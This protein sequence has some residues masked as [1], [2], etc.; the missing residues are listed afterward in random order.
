MSAEQTDRH[1]YKVLGS[2]ICMSGKILGLETMGVEGHLQRSMVT[3][4][5]RDGDRRTKFSFI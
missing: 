5:A 3:K 4:E 1:V 2:Q